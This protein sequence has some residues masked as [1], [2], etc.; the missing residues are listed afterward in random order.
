MEGNGPRYAALIVAAVFIAAFIS[1][2]VVMAVNI[3][4]AVA[5]WLKRQGG[6]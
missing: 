4:K 1:A 5:A 3:V 2:V 6:W